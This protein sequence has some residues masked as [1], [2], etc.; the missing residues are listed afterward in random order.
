M[1]SK[2]PSNEY[3]APK[4]SPAYQTEWMRSMWMHPLCPVGVI[5]NVS[6]APRMGRYGKAPQTVSNDR[7]GVMNVVSRCLVAHTPVMDELR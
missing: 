6:R 4:H 1:A 3:T 7:V 5:R 2:G